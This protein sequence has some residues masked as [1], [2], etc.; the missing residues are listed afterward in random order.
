VDDVK[1]Q[2]PEE[3]H[4][5]KST[6]REKEEIASTGIPLISLLKTSE[7]KTKEAPKHYD[8][9][10]FVILEA[11]DGYRV[12]FSLA[13]L[14]LDAKENPTLL[15]WEENGKPLSSE[16]QPF[17]LFTRGTTR[18]MWGVTRITLVDGHKLADILK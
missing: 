8:Y 1:K 3:I 4:T 10:F 9:Y 11:R 14:M 16:E 2:F 12:Y 17:R 6:G 13:E 15:V 7:L 18:N 5:V